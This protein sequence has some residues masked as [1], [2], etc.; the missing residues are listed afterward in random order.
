[1]GDSPDSLLPD[2]WALLPVHLAG[3]LSARTM[4]PASYPSHNLPTEDHHS[5]AGLEGVEPSWL[6]VGAAPAAVAL[7][8]WW[9][10]KESNLRH[11][12]FQARALPTEL[13]HHWVGQER[14]E[15]PVSQ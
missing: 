9:Y 2:T 6:R 5:M 13:Q 12:E 14:I 15:L 8:P 10:W 11:R 3:L 7:D 1:V 4:V